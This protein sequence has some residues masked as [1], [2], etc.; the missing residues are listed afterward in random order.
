MS[1][2]LSP[3]I[4]SKNGN[5]N[6]TNQKIFLQG[7][8]SNDIFDIYTVVNNTNRKYCHTLVNYLCP[9]NR[10]SLEE[11][12]EYNQR[13]PY[14]KCPANNNVSN[15]L[16]NN[17]YLIIEFKNST[18]FILLGNTKYIVKKIT[19]NVGTMKKIK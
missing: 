8:L 18:S 1:N 9:D 14:Y 16:N 17:K 11:T 13:N 15:I 4:L 12:H 6:I 7:H 10:N 19:F 2:I 5:K 3:I